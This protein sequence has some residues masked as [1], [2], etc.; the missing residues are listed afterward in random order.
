MGVVDWFLGRER[1]EVLPA[2]SSTQISLDMWIEQLQTFGF[3]G[4]QYTLPGGSQE[5]PTGFYSSVVQQAYRTNGIVFACML[6]RML[7]FS[8]ARFQFRRLRS[9]R[10]GEMFGSDEL[11]PL[12]APWP[13]GTTGDMLSRALQYADLAGN[14]YVAR[15]GRELSM[16]RPDWVDII[17]GSTT[18]RAVG[19]WDV[20]ARAVGYVYTPG[21]KGSGNDPVVF[22]AG[23]VAH[24]APIP[25]PL[26]QF[27]GM[28][29]LTPLYREIMSDKAATDHKLRFFE[30]GATPNMLVKLDVD[31]VEKLTPFIEKFREQ[32]EGSS[33]AYRT[34][35]LGAGADATV[36]GA[37]LQQLDFKATQGAGETRIAAAAGVPP[38]IVGLSEGLAGSSLNAGNYG[39]ARR[40]FADG[41]LRP[42]WRNMAGSLANI[43]RVPG[44]AE[45][46][47]D[48]RDI[49]FLKEDLKD[50]AEIMAMEASTIRQLVDGGFLPDSVVSAV[51]AGDLARL[52]HTGK[53]SVQLQD[54]D[55]PSAQ[56]ALEP[57]AP[58]G[59]GQASENRQLDFAL[60]EL[61]LRSRP[62]TSPTHNIYVD[63]PETRVE[64]ADGAIRSD[65]RVEP[66]TVEPARVEFAEGAIRADVNVEPARVEFADGAIRVDT[67]D[68][69]IAEGAVRVDVQPPELTVSEGAIQSHVTV[70][71][72]RIEEGAVQ[73]RVEP[74]EI[75]E[76]AVQVTVEPPDVHVDAPDVSFTA[77]FADRPKRALEVIRDEDGNVVGY[78]EQQQQRKIR[79]QR[80][81]DGNAVKYEEE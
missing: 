48:D 18:D 13:G 78:E 61:M 6:V 76:G 63:V 53:L 80:D 66:T 49:S 57:A 20:D 32:H 3:Q 74:T 19:A 51:V 73:V 4:H 24:F 17:V 41:T 22:E 36:V 72:T 69:T 40:R 37:D 35:F 43:I 75:A 16:L 5:E 45:L 29:W 12:E 55:Q 67:P 56:P 9:G 64:I 54:P 14:A 2:R 47:Y 60:T 38:V 39:M 25:D 77:E 30:N 59:N 26:A 34:L 28:S 44:G 46:W 62:E 31:S 27:R 58:S 68:V 70:E 21:G 42:L 71:P 23:E 10:P 81:K 33:N 50:A 1:Q 11:R 65:V 79:V 52:Q 8:E 7:V 15:R